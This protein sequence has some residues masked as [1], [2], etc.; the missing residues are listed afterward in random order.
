MSKDDVQM[1]FSSYT[2]NTCPDLRYAV[3][4]NIL[5]RNEYC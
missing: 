5:D 1:C 4:K 3:E 2:I